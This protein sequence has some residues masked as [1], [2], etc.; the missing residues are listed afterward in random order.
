[1]EGK[2][3]FYIVMKTGQEKLRIFKYEI[4]KCENVLVM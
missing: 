1:M 4:E 2:E 3:Y